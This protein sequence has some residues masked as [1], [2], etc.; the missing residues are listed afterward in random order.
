[1]LSQTKV[2]ET[3]TVFSGTY[4][5]K[6]V[7]FACAGVGCVFAATTVLD[8]TFMTCVLLVM[9]NT[10]FAHTVMQYVNVRILRLLLS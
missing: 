4:A 7:V 3:L 8:C 10:H 1:V 5:G 6:T 9:Q 2:N